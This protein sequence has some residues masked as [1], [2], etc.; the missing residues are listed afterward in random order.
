MSPR[1]VRKV[2]SRIVKETEGCSKWLWMMRNHSWLS[3]S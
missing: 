3:F 2:N 1:A